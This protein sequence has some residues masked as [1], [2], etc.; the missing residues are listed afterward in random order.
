[1]IS[2]DEVHLLI[3][4]LHFSLDARYIAVVRHRLHSGTTSIDP[5]ILAAHKQLNIPQSTLNC[6]C[7]AVQAGPYLL[8]WMVRRIKKKHALQH[9]TLN[10]DAPA[11]IRALQVRPVHHERRVRFG[12]QRVAYVR[13]YQGNAPHQ[14]S[15]AIQNKH[16]WNTFQPHL[17][18]ATGFDLLL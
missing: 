8:R 5:H 12:D 18:L 7:I 4:T 14:T 6:L 10:P 15:V 3:P 9:R 16:G 1:M 11:Y 17:T 2:Y 13:H